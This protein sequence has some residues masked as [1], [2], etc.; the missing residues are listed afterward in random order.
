M[1]YSEGGNSKYMYWPK[2][3]EEITI[4][5]DKFEKIEEMN[6]KF[7]FT[8]KVKA[9]LESGGEAV[10]DEDQ[11]FRYELNLSDGKVL[12]LNNWLVYY[13]FKKMNIQDG[14]TVHID[15]PEKGKW[16]VTRIKKDDVDGDTSNWAGEDG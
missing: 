12:T 11:G 6:N 1:D 3:G 10:I 9:S 5:I 13:E 4:T 15:H 16:V 7:N 8:K 14:Q 2:I